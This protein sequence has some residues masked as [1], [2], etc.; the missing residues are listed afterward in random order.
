MQTL[1]LS[2]YFNIRGRGGAKAMLFPVAGG[3]NLWQKEWLL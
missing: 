2:A 1:F 3:E